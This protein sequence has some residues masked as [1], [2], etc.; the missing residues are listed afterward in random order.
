MKDF[1]SK[2]IDQLKLFSILEKWL[3]IEEVKEKTTHTTVSIEGIDANKGL[4][5]TNHNEEL[6]ETILQKF[7]V[8][9]HKDID[10][11]KE[12][13]LSKNDNARIKVHTYKSVLASIGAVDLAGQAQFV[14]TA[15]KNNAWPDVKVLD[16]MVNDHQQLIGAIE[17]YFESR[18]VLD[19]GE[20]E[21][22]DIGY[23]KQLYAL[24]EP[25]KS[26]SVKEVKTILESLN[27]YNVPK[28]V[29]VQHDRL[30]NQIKKYKFPDALSLIDKIK[31]KGEHNE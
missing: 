12:A 20:K 13:V 1:I 10:E 3:R 26:G 6:Y 18:S 8:Y 19:S 21:Q 22:D 9:H 14:E 24:I 29:L 31:Q 15:I 25:L 11:I 16:M 27:R 30:I 2:P 7:M 23:F 17:G 4:L 5:H 28:N